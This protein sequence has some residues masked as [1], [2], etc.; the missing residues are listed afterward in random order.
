M[1]KSSNSPAPQNCYRVQ[2]ILFAELDKPHTLYFSRS[3][4]SA[5]S[6]SVGSPKRLIK[7]ERF[8][9]NAYFNSFYPKFWQQYTSLGPL[10]VEITFQGKIA[11]KVMGVDQFE[12]VRTIAFDVISAVEKNSEPQTIWFMDLLEDAKQDEPIVR[13]YVDVTGLETSRVTDLAYVTNKAPTHAVSLSIG[14]CSFNRENELT[15]T[16][17]A[18]WKLKS[19]IP[20][21]ADVFVVN[22]GASFSNPKLLS[23]LEEADFHHIEQGNF[24][25]CGGFNRSMIE[26][27][28]VDNPAAYHLLMDDDIILDA[29][30]IERALHFLG[31]TNREV[32]I[33]GQMLDLFRQNILHE[34]GAKLRK[35]W[36]VNSIGSGEDIA[37]ASNLHLF[38]DNLEI[39][40]NAW[41][42]CMIPTRALTELQFS[43][44]LFIHFDDIEYG[45]RMRKTGT[46][47]L[48]LPGVGVWHEPFTYKKNDW[49]LYYD[50]RNRLI[51][52][53]V[54]PEVSEPPDTL[55]V[56]G[57]IM[58]FVLIHRYRAARLASR[59]IHDFL[60]GP[61]TDIWLDSQQA[62]ERL[63]AF[64][65]SQKGPE[66]L[67]NVAKTDF[68]D[69]PIIGMPDGTWEYVKQFVKSFVVLSLPKIRASEPLIVHGGTH[70]G[71]VMAAPYLLAS[72]EKA[73]EG[74][75]FKLDRIRLWLTTL[76]ALY[77]TILYAFRHKSVSRKWKS[78]LP[79]MQTK[80]AWL[81]MFAKSDP[82]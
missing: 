68:K 47:T 21:I 15:E 44:P 81:R 82:R 22:Q 42:F 5:T 71:N 63:I 23:V 74:K 24:G 1:P 3:D 11:V 26:A 37:D 67:T 10:G 33:G 36:K 12:N 20:E 4:I 38:N 75:L 57:F 25:G 64:L 73:T 17:E 16:V 32:A 56:F 7:G 29:R 28:S 41:W 72:N 65:N 58:N 52:S 66:N 62:H 76:E 34:A 80:E 59:A 70:T 13:L 46:P 9:A 8:S 79:A 54:H 77:L 14:L 19:Q 48:S 35:F 45:C 61:D 69:A 60:S 6:P 78:K 30:V 31:Y 53:A 40:Y 50:L 2:N 18:L 51:N 55:Y 43:P 39:D 27:I 49:M